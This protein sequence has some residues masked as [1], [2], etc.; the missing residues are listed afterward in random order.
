[1]SGEIPRADRGKN[2][3]GKLK[4]NEFERLRFALK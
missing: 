3:L 2:G 1:M 4:M